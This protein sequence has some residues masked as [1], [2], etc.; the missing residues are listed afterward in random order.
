MMLALID[1][2]ASV[3]FAGSMVAAIIATR[4]GASLRDL[5]RGLR[6]YAWAAVA[7]SIVMVVHAITGAWAWTGINAACLMIV[8]VC[9]FMVRSRR[10]IQGERAQAD[11]EQIVRDWRGDPR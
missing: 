7:Q 6:F 1:F 9:A 8:A 4:T 2:T 10:A 11:A 5:G 3:V